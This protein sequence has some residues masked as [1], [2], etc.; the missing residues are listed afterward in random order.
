MVM[1]RKSKKLPR[2]AV[3]REGMRRAAV[4]GKHVG[5]PQGAVKSEDELLHEHAAVVQALAAGDSLRQAAERAGVSVNTVRKVKALLPESSVTRKAHSSSRLPLRPVAVSITDWRRVGG[6]RGDLLV[7]GHFVPEVEWEVGE[8]RKARRCPYCAKGKEDRSL[9]IYAVTLLDR[10]WEMERKTLELSYHRPLLLH[11]ATEEAALARVRRSLGWH[12]LP[13]DT[14]VW[15][16]TD[17]SAAG[18]GILS[19]RTVKALALLEANRVLAWSPRHS[20]GGGIY[21][22]KE[23]QFQTRASMRLSY[24]ECRALWG[25]RYINQHRTVFSITA[26]DI[27]VGCS[28]IYLNKIKMGWLISWN[29]CAALYTHDRRARVS[30]AY[31][32]FDE[33]LLDW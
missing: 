7:C 11:A 20:E 12:K 3:I 33:R 26:H 27:F 16:V 32:E 6:K 19:P 5:R 30:R 2:G 29:G 8:T 15:E 4:S 14:E 22:V 21:T 9:P 23:G 18:A 17:P 13:E 28:A 31:H 24:G 1:A 25:N 10:P